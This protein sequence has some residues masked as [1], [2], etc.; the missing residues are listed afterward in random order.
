MGHA[1][2]ASTLQFEDVMFGDDSSSEEAELEVTCSFDSL[3]T[4]APHPAVRVKL[5]A[6]DAELAALA[7]PNSV[8]SAAVAAAAAQAADD[9]PASTAAGGA[10]L[11]AH[12]VADAL[13]LRGFDAHA[14]ASDDTAGSPKSSSPVLRAAMRH[15]FVVV[16]APGASWSESALLVD[17]SF[18]D[19]FALA[20][21]P[22]EHAALLAA[23]PRVYV[24]SPRRLAALLD[25]LAPRLDAAYAA[26]SLTRPPWRSRAALLARWRLVEE[27]EAAHEKAL[28]AANDAAAAAAIHAALRRVADVPRRVPPLVRVHAYDGE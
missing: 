18:H 4:T 25:R 24:G 15:A 28:A 26:A 10:S 22:P 12:A 23:L 13:R 2:P 11:R 9:L 7:A 8:F 3:A 17:V 16:Q 27:S 21:P 14:I 5:A 20:R 6:S 19:V 1:S